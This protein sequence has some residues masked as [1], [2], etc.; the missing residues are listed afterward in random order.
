MG[1]LVDLE[2]VCC[3]HTRLNCQYR[4]ILTIHKIYNYVFPKFCEQGFMFRKLENKDSPVGKSDD[5]VYGWSFS[6]KNF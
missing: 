5:I 4:P 3:V 1:L 2:P 6:R